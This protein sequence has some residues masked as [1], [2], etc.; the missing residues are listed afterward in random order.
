MSIKQHTELKK[1]RGTVFVVFNK[2]PAEMYN[3]SMCLLSDIT[4]ITSTTTLG[5]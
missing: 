1:V 4:T 2:I 3:S 5:N